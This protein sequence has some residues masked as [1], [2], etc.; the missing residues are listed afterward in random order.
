[1]KIKMAI[2][3]AILTV[4]CLC[5]SACQPNTGLEGIGSQDIG[6]TNQDMGKITYDILDKGP[7]KG[8][9]LN[10]FMT[11]PDTLNPILTN[12]IYVYDLLSFIY[13]GLVRLDEKQRPEPSLSDKWTVSDDGLVW[14]FHIRD[15]MLWHDGAPFTAE[16]AEFTVEAILNSNVVSV[17]KKQLQNV[18]TFAAIDSNNFKIVLRKPN[19]FTAEMMTFP[20]IP[21]HQFEQ[22][23]ITE[24]SKNF[25]PVGTGPYKFTS[26]DNIKVTVNSNSSWWF[27][28]TQG[29]KASD[30]MYI[31]EI[32][33]RKYNSPEDA[34]SAFQIGDIDYECINSGD[35][36]KYNGRTDIIIKKYISANFEFLS[37]NMYNPVFND[38]SVRKAVNASIN[39]KDIIADI[40]HGDAI[41]ADIPILPDS[42]LLEGSDNNRSTLNT[43]DILIAGGWKETDSGFYKVINGVKKTLDIEILVNDN[44]N[45][46]I[47]AAEKICEQLRMFK[48]NA[49]YTKIPWTELISRIDSKKYDMALMG[50]LTTQVPDLS[51]LYSN[52]YLPSFL[53]IQGNTGRNI[54]GY[55]NSIVS[56][57]IEKIFRENDSNVKKAMFIN[58]KQIIED[59]TP[60]IGLYF[61]ENAVI[62]RKNVRGFINPYTWNRYYDVTKWYLPAVQ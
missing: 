39:R 6:N 27:L 41:E 45:S 10:L 50:C 13:E 52:S 7:V 32:N 59:D 43:K 9:T 11:E 60:Y 19:S 57:Y 3:T 38:P 5:F 56:G 17:Y 18:A 55:Y 25:T 12:N 36:S 58:M 37:F 62:Y 14:T 21:K 29:G 54:S 34:V 15:G 23:N 20:I 31:D 30:M 2:I 24:S 35:F 46:R 42:W 4:M 22:T 53:S 1:M 49:T 26:S 44:N 28:K 47:R 61:P 40:L 48:I 16:D 8:G 33:F 51:F